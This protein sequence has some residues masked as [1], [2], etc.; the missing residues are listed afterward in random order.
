MTISRLSSPRD[1]FRIWFY[2][3]NFAILS[4][5]IIVVIIMTFAYLATPL[6]KAS[7]KI[8]ILPRTGEGIVI[9]S[10]EEESRITTVSLQDINTEIE[11]L[12]SEKVICDTISSFMEEGKSL[13]L[14]IE[15][16]EWYHSAI[17]YIKES[18]GKIL[19]FL[20]LIEP[21]KEFDAYVNLMRNSIEVEQAIQSNIII[22]TL[23]AESPKAA[24]V[25]LNR[26]IDIYTKHRN[27]TFTKGE[28]V[29]FYKDQVD[30]YRQ[31]L[32]YAEKKFKD[33][34]KKW[35]IIDL[36]AQNQ[37]N[38]HQLIELKQQL[39]LL[40]GSIAEMENKVVMLKAGLKNGIRFT[41]EMR[42][43]PAIVELEK[44]LVQLYVERSE[45][46]KNHTISSMTYQK[47]DNQINTLQKEV[48]NAVE[49]AITT[50]V[51][52]L[53]ILKKK[54]TASKERVTMVQNSTDEINQKEKGLK[55]LQREVYLLQKNYMLYASK[56]ED[57]IIFSE[58]KKRNL[59][60]ISIADRAEPPREKSFPNRLLFL[61]LSV[62]MG[63]FSATIMPFI[64]ESLDHKIKFPQDVE[65]LLSLPVITSIPIIKSKQ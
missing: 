37:A 29:K 55:E 38:I 4:F 43:I 61:V 34:Q 21:L 2:W 48:L 57:A 47:I 46:L 6:Y 3:K 27:K 30:K 36:E 60:N 44:V 58:R 5:F 64:L 45:V 26:L 19:I 49:N 18:V 39:E 54:R 20:N 16:N 8:L 40:E 56:A 1:F 50:E 62:F 52:E 33:Y 31:K 41:K 35:H 63:V 65:E 14:K 59:D 42:T 32:D 24:A 7:A 51:L 25:V 11:L 13:E 22:I 10:G 28:G 23:E 15:K 9:S 17:N 53:A 12:T